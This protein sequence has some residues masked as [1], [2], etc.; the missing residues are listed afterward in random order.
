MTEAPLA[1]GLGLDR[2]AAFFKAKVGAQV[3]AQA[4]LGRLA[5]AENVKV[6]TVTEGGLVAEYFLPAGATN[7]VPVVAFGGSEGGIGGG[8]SYA[9]RTASL[10]Y[11]TLALAYFGIQGVP[12]EL[13]E[14]PLEYFAKAFAW[15]DKRPETRKGKAVVIG[16]SR[17]GELALLLGATFPNVIGVIAETPSSFRWPGLGPDGKAAW[18]YEGKP[19]AFVPNASTALPP[20]VDAVGHCTIER[21][22]REAFR[23]SDPGEAAVT[24]FEA[25]RAAVAARGP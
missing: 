2:K 14:V 19:L 22:A 11:P 16:G 4:A 23:K 17:G 12:Q 21:L 1:E 13:T 6:E 9:L 5:M 24:M 10:G 15:L 20:T 7:K 25:A 3:V 18:T 8:E